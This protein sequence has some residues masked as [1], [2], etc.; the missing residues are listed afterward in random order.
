M[1]DDHP[2]YREGLVGSLKRMPE[3]EVVGESAT[4]RE[5]LEAIARLAPD[6]AV[7]DIQMAELDGVR[8]AHAISRDELATR[9]L[10]LSAYYD[11]QVVYD[12]LAAGASGFLSKESTGREIADAV[13]AVA[14]GETVLG[15]DIQSALADQIR[16]GAER[17][18]AVLSGREREVLRLVA[19]GRSAPEVARELHVSTTTVKTHLQRAY[20]KLEV[21]DRAAAVAE[22]MRRRLLD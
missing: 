8:V 2:M 11:R 15:R 6:V 10:L 19:A 18:R 21:S 1:A 12:A 5:A 16:R 9:T 4:G 17:D 22:A 7:L 13:A 3:L 14:R 20:E